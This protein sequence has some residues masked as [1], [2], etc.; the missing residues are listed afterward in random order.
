MSCR[1]TNGPP[2]PITVLQAE[3]QQTRPLHGKDITF[4][5][6]LS[7]D[8]ATNPGHTHSNVAVTIVDM[9]GAVKME[10]ANSRP[11]K[12]FGET[13]KLAKFQPPPAFVICECCCALGHTSTGCKAPQR[14]LICGRDHH[15]RQ[16][17]Q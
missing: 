6:W 9:M 14:C 16:H 10:V 2:M 11:L 17:R 12:L 3:I 7:T 13:C 4:I 8:M 1:M 15:T 5:R